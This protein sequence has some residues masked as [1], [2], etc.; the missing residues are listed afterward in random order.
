MRQQDKRLAILFRI[1]MFIILGIIIFY[2]LAYNFGLSFY[3][4]HALSRSAHFVGL[5]NYRSLIHDPSFGAAIIK[6]LIYTLG[7]V[8]LQ[9]ML[10]LGVALLLN[11]SFKGRTIVRGLVLFP[12]IVPPL[13]AALSFKLIFNDMYGI[14]NQFLLSLGIIKQSIIFFGT[15]SLAMITVI[16]IAVWQFF[17]FVAI[18]ILA[19]LQSIPLELYDAGKMDGASSWHLFRYITFPGIK[20]ILAVVVFLRGLWMFSKFDLIWLTTRGGPLNA[21]RT[22]PIHAYYE[23]FMVFKQGRGSAMAFLIFL[24]LVL[25][26]VIYFKLSRSLL[27]E[28]F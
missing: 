22:L 28:E 16:I 12:Y 11:Q 13:V 1:P 2:P 5:S 3:T 6:S 26:A 8:S 9:L 23:V 24:M 20:G 21:T 18:M 19:R 17:P 25:L 7:S 27:R 15:P 4:K 10:G 14:V